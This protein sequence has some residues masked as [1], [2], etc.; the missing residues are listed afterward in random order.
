MFNM[1]TPSQGGRD[2]ERDARVLTLETIPE[3]VA[4]ACAIWGTTDQ[5][6]GC[7]RSPAQHQ[8]PGVGPGTYSMVRD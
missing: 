5:L 7:P 6:P 4:K 2:G 8:N 3:P 1:A